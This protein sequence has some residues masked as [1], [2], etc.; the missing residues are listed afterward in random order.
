M[1]AIGWIMS[2]DGRTNRDAC[3][4]PKYLLLLVYLALWTE[5]ETKL[6]TSFKH[7]GLD[8]P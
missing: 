6:P 4:E 2:Q 1:K 8:M 5:V 3:P 7:L